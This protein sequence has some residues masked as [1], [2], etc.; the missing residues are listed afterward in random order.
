VSFATHRRRQLARRPDV[1]FA[2][3][4]NGSRTRAAPDVSF[5][6]M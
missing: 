6:R 5:A 3:H 4:V 1:S 2:A